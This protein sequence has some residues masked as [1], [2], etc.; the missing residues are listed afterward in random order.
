M[1]RLAICLLLQFIM[2]PAFTFSN[3]IDTKDTRMLSQPSISADHIAFI[4]AEDLWVAN[5]DGSDP[6]RLT[7]AGGIESNPAFSPDGKWIAFT[8]QYDGNTDVYLVPVEGGIPKRLTWH[9]A[10]DIVRGFTP[11]GKSVLFISQRNTFTL[12]YFQLYTVPITGGPAT[13]LEIPNAYWA[14]YSS[15][16]KSMTYTPY[17]DQ[18]KEWKH[19]R[20][21]AI[22]QV[23]QFSFIDRSTTKIPQPEGGSNDVQ[24]MWINGTVYFLSDRNGEFNLFAFDGT[25][26]QA[27][28][29]TDFKDFPVLNASAGGGKVIFEQGG[30][31]HIYDPVMGSTVK[32]KIGIAADLLELRERYANGNKYIRDIDISPSAARVVLDFR[33]EI[34]TVPAEKGDYR[35]LTNTTA[36]HEKSPAW[37]PDGRSI[38]YFSDASGEYQL[39]IQPQDGKGTIKTYQLT[40]TGFYAHPSWSPDGKKIAY[41]DNGRDLYLLDL[42]TGNAAKIDADDYYGGG[43]FRDLISDW[44]ADSKWL[45]YTKVT[46]TQF[47]RIYLYSI[48]QQKSFGLT[49]GLSDASEPCFSLDGKYI[50]FLASTD[51]G[52]V[53]NWFDQSNNDFSITNS[54]YLVTLKN[55]TISPLVKE[56]DEE[57]GKKEDQTKAE[58]KTDKSKMTDAPK[59]EILHDLKI[60]WDGIQ[61]RIVNVPV[62]TGNYGNLAA[63]EDGAVY[64]I[65]Y[66][67]DG[68]NV[69]HK[70]SFK[71]RKDEE[72]MPME[73]FRLSADR[74]KM[75]FVKDGN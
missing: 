38:A 40:G 8:G 13:Q 5:L 24:P 67:T 45:A 34:I 50:Y 61:N 68:N 46:S 14:A 16:G 1:K 15:D 66:G 62:G 52:P 35:N 31:L 12:R 72:V 9:P 56:S 22:S 29:L 2:L 59:S 43:A 19:Y 49:D 65:K 36:V 27:R 74:K 30:F 28:Q 70:F 75:L 20:G 23:W 48:E 53:V 32:L 57:Q 11:D 64:F 60:D 6:R 10:A 58:T 37:S 42:A 63:G 69:L 33:G 54:L 26:K 44:S 25:S 71:T 55:Q 18:F 51:A 4:Y 7:V 73:G 39:L 17:T 21:G 47:K 3:D 41:V